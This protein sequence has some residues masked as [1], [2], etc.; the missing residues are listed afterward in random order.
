M[1]AHKKLSDFYTHARQIVL[2]AGYSWE[3]DWQGQAE[4]GDYDEAVFLREAA[5]VILCSGFRE[6]HVRKIFDFYSL[7]F[8]DWES[9]SEIVSAGDLCVRLACDVFGNHRK[10]KA[11]FE[12]AILIHTVGFDEVKAQIDRHPLAY[13]Q[14]L[15]MLGPITAKHLAKNLGYP[16][17]K[18]DRHLVRLAEEQGYL[19]VDTFC[20][21]ISGMV[22]ESV[23]VVDVTL[24]RYGVLRSQNAMGFVAQ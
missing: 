12:I 18:N 7:A 3:R 2:S 17:A 8:C 9:A 16:I 13:I 4:G 6:S 22:G 5:W 24:W 19:C 20:A 10:A 14:R 11:I 21:E 15:P 1:V 23:P